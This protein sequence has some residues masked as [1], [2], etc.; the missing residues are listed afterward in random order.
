MTLHMVLPSNYNLRT[1]KCVHLLSCPCRK[2]PG[3]TSG[4]SLFGC[5]LWPLV[6]TPQ[7]SIY[8]L[9]T[10]PVAP[11]IGDRDPNGWILGASSELEFSLQI[12]DAQQNGGQE[13]D[14]NPGLAVSPDVFLEKQDAA[15]GHNE[16]IG[17]DRKGENHVA[18]R[19]G[20]QR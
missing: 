12:S 15:G 1:R 8:A 10:A 17:T 6:A 14:G 9:H 18:R 11:G 13:P 4:S 16:N 7:A 2:A 3:G 19:T 5:L 20:C